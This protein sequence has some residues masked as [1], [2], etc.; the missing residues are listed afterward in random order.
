MPYNTFIQKILSYFSSMDIDKLRL[1]L[2]DEYT[3]QGTTKEIFINEIEKIFQAYINSGDTKLIIYRGK[4]A[5]KKC[6]NCGK[7]GYRFVGNHLKNYMDLLFEIE[8]DDIKDIYDCAQFDT[9]VEI[10]GLGKKANI[11]FNVDDRVKF[12]KTPEYW[13]KVYAATAAYSEI[14]TKPPKMLDFEEM[15]YWIDKYADLNSMIGNYGVLKPIMKWTPFSSLY[16]ELKEYRLYI[17]EY[18]SGIKE[19]NCFLKLATSEDKLIDWML[20]YEEICN[21]APSVFKYTFVKKD[22]YYISE[23]SNSFI[24]IGDKFNQTLNFINSY[25]E[26][27]KNLLEKYNTYTKEERSEAFNNQDLLNEGIDVFSLRFHLEKR[28]ALEEIGIDIP[29]YLIT[30][31]VIY[32]M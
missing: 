10:E 18:E 24:L 3:Y 22:K 30:N 14:I 13:A 25:Q 32:R 1:F 26:N 12:R 17:S 29:Y 23:K 20:K 8:G 27:D 6:E 5:G 21:K 19:A 9:D 11:Y 2:K 4:C 28:K 31:P 16:D 15:S 7:K